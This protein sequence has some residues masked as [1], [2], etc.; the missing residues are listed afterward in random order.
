[1]GGSRV[2]RG[3]AVLGLGTGWH[4][5]GSWT[6]VSSIVVFGGVTRACRHVRE[7][8]VVQHHVVFDDDSIGL[9]DNSSSRAKT[10]FHSDGRPTFP[11]LFD[12]DCRQPNRVLRPGST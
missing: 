10:F 9:M 6:A 8:V 3:R 11:V 12:V 1:M 2:S 4:G 5:N 7:V